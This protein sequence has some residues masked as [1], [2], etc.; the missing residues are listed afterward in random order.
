MTTL[1]TIIT[2]NTAVYSLPESVAAA[3]NYSLVVVQMDKTR[4]LLLVPILLP[5]LALLTRPS[6][7]A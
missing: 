1:Q 4:H 7:D 2:P 3:Q 6:L 5:A